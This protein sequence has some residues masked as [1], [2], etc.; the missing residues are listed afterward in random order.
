MNPVKSSLRHPQVIYILTAFIVLAGLA[1]L[2]EMPRRE[3]PKVT[4]RR[5]LVLAAYPGATAEQVEDQV[6]RKI[7]QK[8]FSF[9][10]VRKEKTVA[11]SMAGGVVIDVALVDAVKNA[12][13]FWSKLQQQLTELSFTDLPKG[14]LGPVVRS[15]F[16][17]VIAVMLS[18]SG[19]RYTAD[20]LQVY[21][22]RMETELLRI[23]AVSKVKRIG[24]QKEKIYVT[25]SM[26]QLV[27]YG[28]T[29]LHLVGALQSQNTVAE[30]GA[31]D[32]AAT[33]AP[34]RTTGLYR[35][36]DQVRG[37]LVGMSPQG[38]P[39]YLGDLATVERR[40][41]DPDFL[42]R[43]NGKPAV[44]L[45]L[46][47][48]PGF[49]IVDFG[50]DVQRTIDRV[51][52]GLPPGVQVAAVVNQP[53][54]VE[55][56]ISHF[57]KEFA[58]A[59]ISVIAVT[60]ILLPLQVAV[61]AALAIP[62]TVAMT[63]AIL[64]GIGIELHQ[65][66]L[67]AMIVVL[68]MVVDD[69]IVIADN[70]VEL[71]D[72]G[73]PPDTA[74]W[75][76]ASD[77]AVPVLAA[78][79]TIV[80]AFLP[81]AFLPG[82]MGEFM[83]SLPITVAIAL[84]NSY[85][86]AMLL[87]PLL[88]RRFI[89]KGLHQKQA[90]QAASRRP[91]ALDFMQATYDR[92]IAWAM[93]R[94][95]LTMALAVLAVAA[96]LGLSTLVPQRFF[97]PAER[98]EFAINV[99]MPEGTRLAATD[100][101]VHRIETALAAEKKI[102]TYS[103]FIGMGAP[104]FF[105]SFEPAFPRPNIA[106]IVLHTSA[107]DETPGVVARLREQLPRLV[108]EAEVDVQRL[109]QG[110][111]MWNPVEVR[112]AGPD[113]DTLKMLGRRVAHV[114]DT[115]PGSFMVRNDF[116][117]DSYA[118]Q[119]NLHTELADR[120]G[121]NNAVVSN[122]LAGTFLGLPV[123]TFWEGDKPVDI[124]LRLDESHRST[125]ENVGSTYIVS[126]VARMPLDGIADVKPVWQTSRIVH[127]NG[128]RTI[129]VG[130]F[131]KDGVLPSKVYA[132]AKPVLDTLSLPPGYELKYGGE[133]AIQTETFGYLSVGMGVGVLMIFLILLFLFQSPKDALVVM[134]AIPLALFGAYL[135]LL[136]T[137][138]PFGFTAFMGLISL[139]G[140]VVRNAIIL[141]DYIREKHAHGEPLQD[142][143]LDAGRRRLRPIFLTTAAAAAGLTPMILSAS[144]LW[145]PLA[146]VIAVGLICSMVFTLVAVPVLYV[147]VTRVKVPAPVPQPEPLLPPQAAIARVLVPALLIGLAAAAPARGQ[148]RPAGARPVAAP[149]PDTSQEPAASA[150]GAQAAA[151]AST[152]SAAQPLTLEQALAAAEQGNAALKAARARD[153]EMRRSSSV[154][155]SNFLP[156]VQTQSYY[157][158]SNNTRG[159]LL[160][161]GSLGYFPELGGRFPRTDRTI[162]QGGSDL[163]FAMTTI[164]QPVTQFFK[165]RE[166]WRVARADEVGARADV[167]KAE[168]EVA[169]GVLRA[170]AGA[171]LAQAGRDVA[172][173]R[174]AAADERVKYRA[175]AVSA[176][177]AV[178]V[179]LREARVRSLQAK[180]DLLERENEVDDLTYALADAVGLPAG[181]RLQLVTP[182]DL[183]V[184][185]QP[186][187]EYVTRAL[188]QN[189][190][191]LA[192]RAL[193]DKAAHGV[194][195]ARADYI[196]EIG[197]L[198]MHFFQNSVPFFPKNT[199]A[200]GVAG[201][202]TLFD[203]GARRA[204]LSA[205]RAQQ[206]EAQENLAMVEGHVRGEVEAAYRKA[207]RARITIE[208]A[209]EARSLR[210]EASRL[211]IVQT[212]AGY[213]VP[214]D[215]EDAV[216]DRM[217]AS[218]DYLKAQ[219]GY[220][221]AV[222][223]LQKAA[224][225]LGR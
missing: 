126:Q 32:A 155:F 219:L 94:R 113:V 87:T 109:T 164:G 142:A 62:V 80:A 141:I 25:S 56:R 37:Q 70:Y 11:T 8:L 10:E 154:M 201:K 169:L 4:I 122:T 23:P 140:V 69:A 189:P 215:A 52:Q 194:G 224:G 61:V 17:D 147:V 35:K 59:L 49:N 145:S 50:H 148:E 93:G 203:S 58:L 20:E 79:L 112:L 88:C 76:A 7:E 81:L 134:T 187:E 12:D 176:G 167:S 214:A 220:R 190:E 150:A 108:P 6:T 197:V 114:L 89:R 73:L 199:L 177:T 106:Q 97:P 205:R 83:E 184:E 100:A 46:E 65:V 212:N 117:E 36:E 74:A 206:R 19:D 57:L 48:R 118:L 18:V 188:A 221:I 54:V 182:A 173:E 137:R 24:E 153:D 64:R 211:R 193:V 22:K 90:T 43:T 3:D 185:L 40:Q 129:T 98:D 181:T 152:D 165:I 195:A 202:L 183:D 2:R 179:A 217:E 204:T 115:T 96:G 13:P 207:E 30:A 95:R 125:F 191:L 110:D 146:S 166:G 222:A 75:R 192:A 162:P 139:S 86:V 136:I 33:R 21:L 103:S 208:L 68:G 82:Q 99:W 101:V 85:V 159:V 144:G 31:F 9:E 175:A 78:T 178:D 39:I 67:A 29:P 223:E 132:A 156:R 38:S 14:V 216:A 26:Q 55:E 168:Q 170:Y 138:N 209:R 63:F 1:A 163:L 116:R 72:E 161:R 71:L 84:A 53:K 196:P 47:M 130:S 133:I 157:L 92:T 120:L 27:Q 102:V 111:P 198:G 60:L 5:G 149:A 131:A 119:V 15:D 105:F 174:V 45:T 34:I 180:Q 121:M 135:G 200:F 210:S 172:R 213:A 127:R 104:R 143:A 42:V 51:R 91:N 124:V 77:L 218:L 41:A 158:G 28:I 123:S 44:M 107:V 225:T 128:V 151:P 66:S 16:G 171:L 160:P 186:R